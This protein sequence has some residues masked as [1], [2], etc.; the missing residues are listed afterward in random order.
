MNQLLYTGSQCLLIAS[1]LCT[2]DP[3]ALSTSK[4][5]DEA[6]GWQ[7]NLPKVAHDPKSLGQF[8]VS[9]CEPSQDRIS[10]NVCV[11]G[12]AGNVSAL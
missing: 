8:W 12:A 9:E 3:F 6:S 5:S 4:M 2:F 1:V 11:I 7:S 10:V